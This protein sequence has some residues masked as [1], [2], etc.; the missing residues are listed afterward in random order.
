MFSDVADSN[1]L[2]CV[3]SPYAGN[4]T[5]AL[6]FSTSGND[7]PTDDTVSGVGRFVYALAAIG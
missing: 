7:R 6:E 2:R 3:L 5:S 4:C 1:V